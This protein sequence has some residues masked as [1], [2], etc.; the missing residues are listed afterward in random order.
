MLSTYSVH[1]LNLCPPSVSV[2]VCIPLL[3]QSLFSLIA[4]LDFCQLSGDMA[5]LNSHSQDLLPLKTV[6]YKGQQPYSILSHVNSGI[7]MAVRGVM[8]LFFRLL[9]SPK[10]ALSQRVFYSAS[11]RAFHLLPQLY[12][13]T[14]CSS[15]CSDSAL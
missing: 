7:C 5:R 13:T 1:T 2:R 3:C 8:E 12:F 6:L 9:V 4:V 10:A 14:Y 11:H 15:L